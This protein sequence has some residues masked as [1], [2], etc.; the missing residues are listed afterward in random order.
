MNDQPEQPYANPAIRSKRPRLFNRSFTALLITQFFTVIN[1]NMFRWLAIPLAKPVLGD[2][3]SLSLGLACFT[4]PYLLVSSFAGF[5]TDR[6]SKRRVIVVCK[7]AEVVLMLLGLAAILWGNATTL[8]IVVA[9]TGLQSALFS[10]AKYAC[11]P[12]LVKE[13]QLSQANG[14]LGMCTVIG[15]ALGAIAGTALSVKTTCSLTVSN[16]PS[17]IVYPALAVLSVAAFGLTASLMIKR[18]TAADPLRKFSAN[19]VRET[20]DGLKTLHSTRALFRT[21][22]GIG[23]FWSLASLAQMNTDSFGMHELSLSQP[24]VGPLLGML[25]LGSALGAVVA[26]LISGNHVELGLVPLGATGI[27]ICGVLLF[28]LGE[29]FTGPENISAT[30]AFYLTGG[31][32]VMLGMCAGLFDIPLEAHL[33]QRSEPHQRGTILAT[34][35]F[36]TFSMILAAS[37]VFYVLNDVLKLS[38]SQIFLWVG[39]G[40]FPITIYVF[41]LIPTATIRMVVYLVSHF[42]FRI[43]VHGREHIPVR[44][45]GLLVC[46]HVSWIDGVL[47]IMTST[48]PIR[49]LA[50]ADYV[51]SKWVRWLT[52]MYGT[53]P[54]KTSDGPKS[55]MRSLKSAR[56]AIQQGDL[57]CIFAEGGLTRSGQLQAFQRGM[58]KII[59]G[60]DAPVIPVYL[61]E[62]WG[63]VFSFRGGKFFWKKPRR[64]PYPITIRFGAALANVTHVDQVRLAVQELG[65]QAVQRRKSRQLVPA[66]LFLRNCKRTLFRQ[67]IADSSGRTMNGG[68]LLTAALLL[69]KL[70]RRRKIVGQE[71]MIGLLLPPSCGGA[72]ANVAVTLSRKVVV[73]LNYTLTDHDLNACID[74]C[75]MKYVITSKKL[76]EK[77]PFDINAEIILLEDLFAEVRLTEKI[78]SLL[79]AYLCPAVVLERLLRLT[80][81]VPDDLLA[82]IFTSGSTGAPK[83]VMLSQHNIHSNIDAVDQIFNLKKEDTILGVLPYFH[84]FGYTITLW[85][86]LTLKPRAVYHFNPLDARMIGKLVK[87]HQATIL[88]AAPTF[89]RSYLKRCTPEELQT[90]NLVVV[91][92]EKLPLD[93]AEAYQEKF[94]LELTEGYGTTELSPVA[95]CNVPANRTG[96]TT[97][98]GTKL[99]TVGRPLPGVAAKIVAPDT[100]ENLHDDDDEGL[101]LIKG[102][103]VMLGYL[104]QPEKTAEVI[105]DGWYVTGD[106]ARIDRDGFISITGRQSRFSKIG[107]EMVP[108]LKIEQLLDQMLT[109]LRE[110][111]NE[112]DDQLQ[113]AVTAVPD[114]RKGERLIVIHRPLPIPIDEVRQQLAVEN[115]PN[116]WIPDVDAFLEVDQIP[117]LGSGKLDLKQLKELAL[118]K[119]SQP[120]A[121][122]SDTTEPV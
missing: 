49:M 54:I 16:H 72:I 77:R 40:T 57:V 28:Q 80:A 76:F 19:I 65:V 10:P 36:I 114:Q 67:Q 82:V 46:N 75:D 90:L 85:L 97:Q 107:G 24:Q 81:S 110:A 21:A 87:Q 121:D 59:D 61:D 25:V 69:R 15:T 94:N 93:L 119:F 39:L 11:L 43:R 60:I 104:N 103:N 89:L 98:V 4:L 105:K 55:L 73:N 106:I 26:G 95:S 6:F 52:S 122:S 111:E 27:S 120:S 51:E 78:S 102:A 34:S 2:A 23:F 117:L 62:L 1:D 112:E 38:A 35:N 13:W 9:L 5:L 18:L 37:G 92:A 14:W 8:F 99:G 101:L 3:R 108:H 30:F 116:L 56:E 42:F 41:S 118:Q 79:T 7:S 96:D 32:L 58:L 31:L 68:K 44:G 12:E 74:Q 66:R 20:I 113:L 22:L 115:V 48:R 64:W 45:G 47:L 83:G 29:S 100:F 33:Q 17:E 71:Q 63:S 50:Y 84:S 86:A 53:I 109:R 70:L 91:G 88:I